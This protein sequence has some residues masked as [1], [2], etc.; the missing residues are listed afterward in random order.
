MSPDS[1]PDEVDKY[2]DVKLLEDAY[3]KIYYQIGLKHGQRVSIGIEKNVKSFSLFEFALKYKEYI[4]KYV[5]KFL[6]QRIVTVR[7]SY[8]D[9]IKYL[10][11]QWRD[12]EDKN[13]ADFRDMIHREFTV[14][15]AW[16][17]PNGYKWQALRIA[18][19][20]AT[21]A[22]NQAALFAADS[23]MYVMVKEW[24][25][26]Q[27]HRTRRHDRGVDER[28]RAFGGDKY[29][30]YHMNGKQIPLHDKFVMNDGED[31]LRFPGD[32]QGKAADVINC[33]CTVA[34]IP[35]RDVNGNLI[36]KS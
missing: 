34:P 15:K 10:W 18:R 3:L 8:L 30:H 24:I 12:E 2:F 5:I 14:K 31:Y 29:D 1:F 16:I 19:T 27:D 22:A 11:R 23:S 32:P 36:R 25:S 33:R 20:E 17:E 6:G 7:K 21:A 4:L 35:A 26:A 13:Y 28:G 9:T